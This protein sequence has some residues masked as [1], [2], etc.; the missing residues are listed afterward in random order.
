MIN[1]NHHG[2]FLLTE[3]TALTRVVRA[4]RR[5]LPECA[6]QGLKPKFVKL[7]APSNADIAADVTTISQ[8]VIRK[9]RKMGPLKGETIVEAK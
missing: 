9:L 6:A 7:S 3:S 1:A 5:G 4:P 8:R 2:H